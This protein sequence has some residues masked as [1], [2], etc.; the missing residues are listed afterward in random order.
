M[1]PF[2][3][4]A[5]GTPVPNTAEVRA[6]LEDPIGFLAIAAAG[7]NGWSEPYGGPAGVALLSGHIRDWMDQQSHA[8][9]ALRAVA[10]A[11][12]V[13][14]ESL[15]GVGR[16]LGVTK[17]AVDRINKEVARKPSPFINL[18]AEGTW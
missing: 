9:S 1:I 10:V 6:A 3:A 7:A 18:L 12:L 5:P 8:F 17:S 2:P 15:A 14:D 13:R 4:T 11:E 16:I